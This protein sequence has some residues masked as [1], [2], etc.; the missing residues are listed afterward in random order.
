MGDLGGFREKDYMKDIRRPRPVREESI[1]ISES[2][3]VKKLKRSEE[4]TIDEQKRR[5]YLYSKRDFETDSRMQLKNDVS[6]LL[7]SIRDF[8]T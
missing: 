3:Y 1:F 5:H 6:E 4:R 2:E 7:E 8:T